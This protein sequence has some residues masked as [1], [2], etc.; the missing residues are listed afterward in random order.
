M[1]DQSDKIRVLIV[2]DIADTRDN[3]EKLL[4]F[5]KDMQVV[6]KAGTGREAIAQ[7]KQLQPDVI[8]MDINMPDMDGIAAT[9]AITTQVPNTEVIMM[10]V[11]G[12]TDYLRRAM[13]AGARQFLTKPVGGDELASSIREVYRLRQTRGRVVSAAQKQE[14][15]DQ[16]TGQIIAVYSP[17][18]GTG[19]SAVACNL[20]VAL[21]LLP[22]NR[23]VCLVDANLL[24]G[25]VGVM[26]N[27]NTSK[28]IND[29]TSR[30][31]ELD[32]D[33]LNDVMSSHASG[34]KVLV[35]PPNPQMGELVTADHLRA[36][37]EALRREFDYVVVDTQSSFQDQTMAVLDAAARIVLLMTM[38]LSSIK[39]IRQFLEVAELLEYG[40]DK[41]VLVLNKAD[42]RFGIR[43][44]QVE[45]NIQ[46]KVAA[47]IGN[48]PYEM[49]SAINRGVPLIID[50]Q[51]H[52]VSSDITNLAYL[53]SGN[54]ARS[55]AKAAAKP[56][57]AASKKE[58]TR[59]LF[60][61]LTKR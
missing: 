8:L 50:K 11:Q 34:I 23:K 2:D 61:R 42:P 43:V 24:F 58:E 41:L 37:M 49:T 1:A 26:F 35:A 14:E 21:K 32:S 56:A 44:D 19:K 48:A 18:G 20:A 51:G 60:A 10:S 4:F 31:T 27:I 5:E 38:E 33:L 52:Q 39:N 53:V 36:I 30:I 13:L 9:E 12:E 55:A 17:K 54:A 3:L 7:A 47:Q 28:T 45:A 25:D 59:G 46:H 22:G 40:E 57:A 16:V 29:L 6:G 15:S